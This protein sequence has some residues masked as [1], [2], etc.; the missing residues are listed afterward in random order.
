M[1]SDA[2]FDLGERYGLSLGDLIFATVEAT[3]GADLTAKISS[4]PT[5]LI[6]EYL[7]NDNLNEEDFACINV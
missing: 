3:N 2:K 6:S 7:E 4:L 1:V 5:R